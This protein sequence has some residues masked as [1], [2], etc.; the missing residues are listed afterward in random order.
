M[1][2]EKQAFVSRPADQRNYAF[3]VPRFGEEIVGGAETLV[4]Q[5]AVELSKRGNP[6]QIF[7]TCAKDNRSWDNHY[8]EGE[9]T[10]F[11]LPVRRFAVDPR[12]LDSWIPKQI[13]INDGLKLSVDDQLEW[14]AESV[15]SKALY[16]HLA[17]V[18]DQFDALFFAPYLFGTTFWGSMVRPDKS[19][20]IPCLHDEHY[21]YV[22]IIQSMMRQ[23]AGMLF[24]AGAEKQL[25][26]RIIGAVRGGEVGMGFKALTP[27]LADSSTPYFKEDFPYLLYFGRKE[28][29]KN[30][31]LLVDYFVGMKNGGILPEL[32]LVIFGGGD[33]ADLHRSE[34]LLREDII[35]LG[36][37]SEED[38]QRLIKH[39]S[40][41]CN[42][43]VNESFSI[44]LME[45]W[46]LRVPV[47]VHAQCEVTREHVV[48][49]GGGLYFANQNEFIESVRLMLE[50]SE[51]RA[52]FASAGE[53]YVNDKYSWPAV[54]KRFDQ[55][56]EQFLR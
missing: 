21:A 42:P 5:L 45:A 12:S 36:H 32:K 39:A 27:G 1:Q 33:F 11:S 8:P 15:N 10:E 51:I 41:V 26:E 40:C 35:D 23:V 29:G 31:Q 3:I 9:A 25:A 38:K 52:Q 16:A 2:I 22:D 47:L 4:A 30:V 37:M 49:A 48:E 18:A 7:T 13:A 20:L 53:H 44:V 50:D 46:Q 19:Y 34:A 17:Q 55:V 56:M 43:S 6:V 54:L 24:N 28:T 14:M